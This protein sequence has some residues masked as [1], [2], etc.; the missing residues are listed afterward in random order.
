MSVELETEIN[1]DEKIEQ[2][3]IDPGKY[4]VVM[5]N[6]DATPMDFVVEVLVGIFKHSAEVAE[7]I[8]MEIHK[9]GSAVVGIYNF[10]IAEQKAVETTKLSRAN[11]FPLQT[12]IEKE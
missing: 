8:T 6:D 7:A 3:V 5:I 10:E 1:I 4:K 9:K 11:G 2:L 12:V